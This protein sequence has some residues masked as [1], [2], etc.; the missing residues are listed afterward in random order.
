MD[1]AH[2]NGLDADTSGDPGA[3]GGFFKSPSL[4][5]I[6]VGA[7]YM[8]DGRL[9]NLMEVVEFYNSG[10]QPHPNLSPDLR[11]N[12]SPT[13]PPVRMNLDQEEKEALVAFLQ[14]LTDESFLT[15]PIFSDPFTE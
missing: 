9:K 2:I 1:Q 3:G 12:G 15:N 13:G 10:V 8:H 4:R 6:A 14:T 7:P 11:R 5:N